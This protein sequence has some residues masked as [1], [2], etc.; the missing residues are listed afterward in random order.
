MEKKE[1]AELV[2]EQQKRI[3]EA[4]GSANKT[5]DPLRATQRLPGHKREF[6]HLIGGANTVFNSGN[7]TT[8]SNVS[9]INVSAIF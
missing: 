7:N 5:I 9:G 8:K 6:S 2:K 4:M 3:S 1:K